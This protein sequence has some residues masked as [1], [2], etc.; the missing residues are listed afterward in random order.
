MIK[1]NINGMNAISYMMKLK[2]NTDSITFEEKEKNYLIAIELTDST[3]AMMDLAILYESYRYFI[4]AIRYYEMALEYDETDIVI[5]YNFADMYMRLSIYDI[6]SDYAYTLLD[7]AIK[8]F[9]I[10]AD[11]NDIDSMFCVIVNA[12]LLKSSEKISVEEINLKITKYL[13]MLIDHPNYKNYCSTLSQKLIIL[14]YC[15]AD[16]GSLPENIKNEKNRLRNDHDVSIYKNKI[17]LFTK[18]NNICECQICYEEKLNIDLTCGHCFCTSCY[19]K[20][21]NNPCPVCKL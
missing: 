18:L 9:S 11:L 6:D 10:A 15:E 8:H 19:Q 1:Y 3:D 16:V 4:K 2:N 14:H 21:Y 7:I 5:R 13:S 12:S 17:Q 20:I